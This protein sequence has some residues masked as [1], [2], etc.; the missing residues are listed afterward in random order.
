MKSEKPRF[1][2]SNYGGKCA[3]C[4]QPYEIGD[5][6]WWKRH[7]PVVHG[8]CPMPEEMRHTILRSVGFDYPTR[9]PPPVEPDEFSHEE[10]D[11]AST[12]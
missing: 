8:R 7:F 12:E 1:I 4:G 2:R 3:D 5:F 10:D 9:T 11:D 6:I